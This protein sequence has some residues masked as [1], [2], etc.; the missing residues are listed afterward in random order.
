[1][2]EQQPNL[3]QSIRRGVTK[4]VVT[5][6]LMFG[7]GFAMVPLYDVICD[8]TGL[9]GKTSDVAAEAIDQVDDSRV[10]ESPSWWSRWC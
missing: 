3:E 10:V 2:S 9:N 1:M 5:V 7:F 4:L 8:I 6:V